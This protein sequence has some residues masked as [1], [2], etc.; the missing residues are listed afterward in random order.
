MKYPAVIALSVADRLRI[1]PPASKPGD[2]LRLVAIG[3]L[4]DAAATV[5]D[6]ASR[7]A[8]RDLEFQ[9]LVDYRLWP[10]RGFGDPIPS[11]WPW[12][13]PSAHLAGEKAT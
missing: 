13:A 10:I 5:T 1:L 6:N 4:E 3:M 2:L 12:P 11:V 7:A 9:A 8:F